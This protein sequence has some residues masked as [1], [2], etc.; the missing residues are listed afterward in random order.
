MAEETKVIRI[1]VD[2]SKAAEGS[3]AATRALEKI[4]RQAG[5]MDS[6]MV[7]LERGL[8]SI[9]VMVKTQLA[10]A[11]ADLGSR[12]LGMAK[13]ALDSAAGLAELAEQLGVTTDGLQALQFSAAQNG[14]KM[15]QLETGI[16]KFSQ[17][18]GE[19]ANGSKDMVEAL[20]S[21]GIKNLD[22]QGKLRPTEALLA[23]VAQAIV[24]IEDPAKRAAAAVDFFG[25]AGTRFLPMLNDLAGGMDLLTAR[26]KA[27]GV[28]ISADTI[29]KLDK[30]A[31][32]AQ[33][34]A[35]HIKALF[36]EIAAPV[37]TTALERVNGLLGQIADQ[38][39]RGK[40]S[41]K[42][43]WETVLNDSRAQGQIGSGPNALKLATPEQ[44]EAYRLSKLKAELNNPASA[45]R[46]AQIQEDIDRLSRRGLVERQAAMASEEEW[47]RRIKLP[48]SSTPPGASTS[49]VKGAGD[50][51][52]KRIDKLMLDT[53]RDLDAAKAFAAASEAGAVAVEKLEIHFKAL[54]A[55]QDAFG[56]SAG[57]NRA[58]VEALTK[59]IE[60]QLAATE[61]LKALKEFNLG[62]EELERANELLA[63][64]NGLINANAEDRAREIALIRLKQDVQAK[65]LDESNAKE[66]EAIER[67]AA[68]IGQNERLKAQGEELK[69]A[70]ELWTEPLK[71]A[72]SSIQ[73]T[74]ADA[75]A[76]MLESGKFSFQALG[77]VVKKTVIRMIAEF[78][79]LAVVRPI[80]GSLIGGLQGVGL[81][82]GA[83]ASSLGFGSAGGGGF[84]MPSF[85]GAGGGGGMFGF[86]NTPITGGGIDQEIA[87]WST[88]GTSAQNSLG[89]ALGGL[90]WG[91][92]LAG[93]ASIGMGAY[94]LATSKGTAGKIGGALGI[95]GGGV[96]LA[97]AAGLLP[98]LGA[99]GGPIGM[100]IGLVGS[101]LPMLLGGGEE[102]K[103]D[104]LAGANARFDPGA[105]GYSMSNTQQLGGKSIAGM[106]GGVSGTIDALF[107]ATG[108]KV[109]PGMAMSGSVWN[110]Q[111]EGT[112]STYVI[113]PTQGSLQLSEGEGDQSAAVDRMIAKIFYMTAT[114]PGALTGASPTLMRAL[115]NKEPTTTA[116]VSSLLELVKAYDHLGKVTGSAETA[117]KGIND[118]FAAM[119]AGAQEYGLALAPIEAEQA[120]QNKRA[121]QDF[122]DG[123][124]DPLA[125]QLRALDD[126]RADSLASAEYIRDNVKDVYVD[127]GKITEYWNRKRLDL[128]AQYQEASVGQLQ[129]LVRRLTYGDLANASPDTSLAGTRGT[130]NATLA[131]ARA[132][133]GVALGNLAGVAE[134]FAGSARSYFASGPEYA[135]IVEQLRRDLL[136]VMGGSGG[137]NATGA[138]NGEAQTNVLLQ[139]FSE[140]MAAFQVSQTNS[141]RLE[142]RVSELTAQ[143][144]RTA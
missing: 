130:Y 15:E 132:G 48:E 13:S 61:K 8:S 71:T 138:A 105:N 127:I 87:N 122:I 100:G 56:D 94:G 17:K 137:A 58:L 40:A 129:A 32:R 93:V 90:T 109:T 95:L 55:A 136:E 12:F 133:S 11:V 126:Q 52:R 49:T 104:P 31:D 115:G 79:A 121:A 21:L 39:E 117:L 50:D 4:E 116:A 53:G 99:A 98:M 110:N 27:A 103:W 92:G 78:A 23:E 139:Q 5:S 33:V 66:K 88:Y 80:M 57:K 16:S 30:M 6:T 68:A 2:A 34:S 35:Q 113:S 69:K 107:K 114:T 45:G 47:A 118:S 24:G 36:A 97:S 64:E 59:K 14:V 10:L 37:I 43:F 1:I 134:S 74:A 119:T 22:F 38:L 44:M 19:A 101:L 62:T 73:S 120:K 124:L 72:L 82:S 143:L 144:Q 63:A 91:Q 26:A 108:G 125:V 54:K 46:E 84:S 106:Y 140:L 76:G 102:Y 141:A 18:L 131:Q 60:E 111:R 89:G 7:R 41:G 77:D 42:G 3:S 20:T 85:G 112:T 86:L 9:A 123:M 96:G 29:E 28:V 67:R 25:K 75:F 135:A 128:E 65:G 51:V 83:T 70:N 81:V 142:S